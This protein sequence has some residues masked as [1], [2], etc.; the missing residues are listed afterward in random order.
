MIATTP[1]RIFGNT[2]PSYEDLAAESWEL[3][4]GRGFPED[5]L[6]DRLEYAF[7][8]HRL[9]CAARWQRL[10]G[11]HFNG[12]YRG[13]VLARLAP[14][15]AA[16]LL[17]LY[18][19]EMPDVAGPRPW[20]IAQLLLLA[21]ATASV[22]GVLHWPQPRRDLAYASQYRASRVERER[23]L[24]S[25]DGWNGWRAER[26]PDGSYVMVQLSGTPGC[27]RSSA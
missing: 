3:A 15:L 17:A 12:Y 23:Q 10:G 21:I 13:Y 11:L 18:L 14:A 24:L 20:V 25:P 9:A 2:V 6:R 22:W 8:A 7:R 1:I 5:T 19:W 4:F 16:T 27:E 26:R